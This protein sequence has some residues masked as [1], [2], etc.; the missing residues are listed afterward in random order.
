MDKELF[1]VTAT[2]WNLTNGEIIEL[3]Y[4]DTF[5]VLKQNNLEAI[6]IPPKKEYTRNIKIS[7]L[8]KWI[9]NCKFDVFTLDQF[10]KDYPKQRGNNRLNSHIF[11][12]IDKKVILQVGIEKFKIIR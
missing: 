1:N 12:L 8:E 10:F 6:Y 7:Y 4:N 5:F 11:N 2:V 9:R 3:K